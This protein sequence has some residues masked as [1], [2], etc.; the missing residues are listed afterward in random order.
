MELGQS[1]WDGVVEQQ[2]H[3]LGGDDKARRG[4]LSRYQISRL[5]GRDDPPDDQRAVGREL[6]RQDWSNGG[7]LHHAEGGGDEIKYDVFKRLSLI[8]N[9]SSRCDIVGAHNRRTSFFGR[10]FPVELCYEITS[11]S[12]DDYN[13]LSFNLVVN[14]VV[15]IGI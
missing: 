2:A 4:R 9:E 1:S 13:K 12:F 14:L 10:S 8:L 15:S 3:L 5:Y 6:R 7:N 11:A